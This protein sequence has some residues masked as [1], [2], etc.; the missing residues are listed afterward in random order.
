MVVS[1]LYTNFYKVRDIIDS[2][3]SHIDYAKDCLDYMFTLGDS[4]ITFDS[5][6][7]NATVM[8]NNEVHSVT[9]EFLLCY[10]EYSDY[11]Y[12][13]DNMFDDT[14]D[15]IYAFLHNCNISFSDMSSNVSK[16]VEFRKSFGFETD[17]ASVEFL[18]EF[19][20]YIHNKLSEL[21]NL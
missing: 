20:L 12:R 5:H 18:Q 6:T 9:D 2:L 21:D 19:F 16:I 14:L 15:F 17:S 13:Y 7:K 10:L 8:V 3:S 11:I 4:I 1:F